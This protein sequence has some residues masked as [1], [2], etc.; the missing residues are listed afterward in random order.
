[1]NKKVRLILTL[2]EVWTMTSPRDLRRFTDYAR[3]A[4][5]AGIAGLM[6]GEHPAMGPSADRDGRTLNPR[7]WLM[8]YNQPPD[9]PFPASLPLL[10]AMAA[11]TS[12]IRLIAGAL[13]APLRPP[14]LMA[15]E[16]ATVD[17]LSEGR[18]ALVPTVSWQPE[19]YEAMGVD[20]H[21]RGKMLDEQLEIWKRLWTDG[22]PVSFDGE[23]YRFSDIHIEPSPHR[24]GGPAIWTGGKLF[25][26]W[27]VRRVVAYG[28]GLFPIVP[29][30]ADQFAELAEAMRL[31][32]RDMSGLE[33]VAVIP[34]PPFTEAD[35]LLD[36]DAT[37]A[38]APGLVDQGFTTLLLKPSMFIDDGADFEE[39]CRSALHKLSMVTK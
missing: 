30:S 33:L 11:V 25:S 23:F 8:A 24:P 1:M 18:L 19:E 5:E 32:G 22:S 12:K 35:G 29:P 27:M 38:N 21:S 37:I 36:L 10:A 7:D 6:V 31:A 2:S 14:L 15:K 39:F 13:L 16:L 26:P 28:S 3:I 34:T 20:F 9:M 4:E 17:L